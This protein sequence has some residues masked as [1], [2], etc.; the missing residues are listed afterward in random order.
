M[1]YISLLYQCFIY[2]GQSDIGY[3]TLRPG[4]ES[5]ITIVLLN[6]GT[7]QNFRI[8]VITDEPISDSGVEYMIDNQFPYVSQNSQ[9]NVTVNVSF[10]MDGQPGLSVTFIVVAESQDNFD[11]N[12]FI[13]FDVVNVR[14]VSIKYDNLFAFY[15]ILCMQVMSGSSNSTSNSIMHMPLLKMNLLITSVALLLIL[16]T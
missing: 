16:C 7:G 2:T 10:L 5:S 3:L 9:A 12:D 13:T 1:Q 11:I 15:A 4:T 6:T 14:E 8:S